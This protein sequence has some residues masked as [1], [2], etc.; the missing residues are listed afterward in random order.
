VRY[1]EMF[2]ARVPLFSTSSLIGEIS[3]VP[4]LTEKHST[5]PGMF[6][7]QECFLSGGNKNQIPL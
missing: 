2:K 7:T 5:E 4:V 1:I 3:E 6:I